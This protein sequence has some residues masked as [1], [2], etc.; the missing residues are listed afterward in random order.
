MINMEAY[1]ENKAVIFEGLDYARIF[2]FLMRKRYDL[3]AKNFV[4][5]NNAFTSDEEIIALLKERTKKFN[6]I[7][8]KVTD[9]A[10]W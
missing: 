10:A 9:I 8:F 1:A 6:Q 7:N 5:I 3:L 4:N 2:I